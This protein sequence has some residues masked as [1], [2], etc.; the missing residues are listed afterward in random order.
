MFFISG[1]NGTRLKT[2]LWPLERQLKDTKRVLPTSK[3][4]ERKESKVKEETR[5]LI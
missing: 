1:D 2:F 5:T 3:Y 4:W